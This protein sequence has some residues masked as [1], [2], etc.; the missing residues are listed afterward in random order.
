MP[1]TDALMES[2]YARVLSPLL[3]TLLAGLP[4]LL[5]LSLAQGDSRGESAALACLIGM[6]ALI[7]WQLRRGRVHLVSHLLVITLIAYTTLG[8]IVYGSVRSA[9][10]IGFAGAIAAAGMMLNRKSLVT[11]VLVCI[12]AIGALTWSESN[13]LLG[14]VD[15]D[16]GLKLWLTHVVVLVTVAMSVHAARGMVHQALVEQRIELG[17]RERAEN[18]LRL[19][20]DRYVRVFRNSPVA[21]IVQ[22]V[23][24]TRVLDVNP[25]FE[26]LYGW[27]RAELVGAGTDAVL[28]ASRD[29]RRA[30][31]MRLQAEGRISNFSAKGARKDGSQFDA[32]IASELEG[33][34]PGQILVSNI[35]DVSAE[36]QAREQARQSQELFAKAFDFSPVNMNITRLSDGTFLAVN[37]AEDGVQGYTPEE[38]LGRTTVD[39][40]AWLNASERELFVDTLRTNGQVLR[41]ETQMRHKKGHLVHCLIWAVIVEIGGESCVLSS[42]INITEQKRRE[43]QLLELARGVSGET[44]ERFFQLLVQHLANALDADLVMVGEIV[45]EGRL[46]SLAL[47]QD[48]DQQGAISYA[49]EG[50]PCGDA[51]EMASLCNYPDDAAALFPRDPVLAEGKFRA[52]TGFALRDADGTAIGILFAAWRAAQPLSNDRDARFSIFASR[53]NAELVRLRRDR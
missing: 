1:F 50:T 45:G 31:A 4:V 35:T 19:S 3:L 2:R 25:A 34:G 16:V 12:A 17:R 40:G 33:V 36:K 26:R 20:E 44:G 6:L 13:G 46:Q 32:Q 23:D 30:F 37:A 41:Y 29:E 39:A 52:Y 10:I 15:L 43:G 38:L 49:L 7:Y 51:M 48:G 24:D 9:G 5:V 18:E 27:Q 21:I 53:T 28:W 11:A 8:V 14:R 47:M 42:S 22:A